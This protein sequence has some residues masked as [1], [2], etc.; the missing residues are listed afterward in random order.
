MEIMICKGTPIIIGTG[1][2]NHTRYFFHTVKSA[3]QEWRKENGMQ[4]R[5]LKI[6]YVDKFEFGYVY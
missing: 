3:L 6:V 1:S 5:H 4:R 2:L